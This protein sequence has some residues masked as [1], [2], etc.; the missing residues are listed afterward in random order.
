M[1]ASEPHAFKPK[2]KYP[3]SCT[4]CGRVPDHEIHK[5]TLGR[6]LYEI[7]S[8]VFAHRF[9][10]RPVLYDSLPLADERIMWEQVGELFSEAISDKE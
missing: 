10:G 8:S 9:G 2:D 5:P 1:A 3:N 6:Q 7:Y 4:I